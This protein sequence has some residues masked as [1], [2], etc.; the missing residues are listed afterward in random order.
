M[1]KGHLKVNSSRFPLS[2]VFLLYSSGDSLIGLFIGGHIT[3]ISPLDVVEELI[4][5]F[6]NS[7]LD[8]FLVFN[9]SAIDVVSDEDLNGNVR[10]YMYLFRL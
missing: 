7:R 6:N 10:L 4:R 2:F 1:E 3:G 8:S 9:P 5:R